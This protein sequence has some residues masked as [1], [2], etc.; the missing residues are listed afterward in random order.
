MFGK[1]VKRYMN[2]RL[3][4][5]TDIDECA[6]PETNICHSNA[7]CNNT[8]GSFVCRCL[9][10]YQGDGKNCTGKYFC[11]ALH[12]ALLNFSGKKKHCS[13]VL[14]AI[15]TGCFPSCGPNAFCQDSDGRPVC[16]CNLGYQ[17]DGYNCTGLFDRFAVGFSTE[18]IISVYGK[19]CY[20][21]GDK[22]N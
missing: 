12:W 8:E 19:H 20:I 18:S 2:H 6:S 3:C 22:S 15:V 13:I 11:H 4:L 9:D 17:G 7:S 16:G 1:I 10:G 14:L 5:L 21:T